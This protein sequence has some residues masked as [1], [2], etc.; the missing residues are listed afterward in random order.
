MSD[1]VERLTAALADRYAIDH[2]I[3]RGGMPTVYR[4]RDLKHKRDVAIK[5]LRSELAVGRG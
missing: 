3:G 4:A 2:G 5:V 1:S